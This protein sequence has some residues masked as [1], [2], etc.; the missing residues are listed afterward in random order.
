[1]MAEL[2]QS[3]DGWARTD[4]I[5]ALPAWSA[6]DQLF[7]TF[8]TLLGD[9]DDRVARAAVKALGQLKD[10]RAVAPLLS[11]VDPHRAGEVEDALK[12]MGAAAEDELLARV[13]DPD[14]K[15]RKLVI[16]SLGEIGTQKS[17]AALTKQA[18]SSDFFIKTEAEQALRKVRERRG[19]TR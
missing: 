10:P 13:D 16:K 11:L 8:V 7:P 3:E 1:M 14:E 9:T 2:R 12:Q 17:E 4:I 18:G 6:A 19:A 15:V 5:E